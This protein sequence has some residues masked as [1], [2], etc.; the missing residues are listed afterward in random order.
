VF[1]IG[2]FASIFSPNPLL[3]LFAGSVL[4]GAIVLLWPKNDAPLLLLP[5][6]LQ[7]IAVSMKPLLTAVLGIPINQLGEYGADLEP[8][9]YFALVSLAALAIGMRI[10]SSARRREGVDFLAQSASR[11]RGRDV[12]GFSLAVMLFGHLCAIFWWHAGSAQQIVLGL[13]GIRLVGLFALTYWCLS[14]KKQ[15]GL[16]AAVVIF[17]VGFGMTG[18]FA[19][20]TAAVMVVVIA[21]LAATPRVRPAA[22]ILG[23]SGLA[24]LL[25][26]FVFWSAIKPDYR[27]FI[28][29]GRQDHVAVVPM[30]DRLQY[31][32]S[33]VASFDRAKF[34]DGFQR[35]VH[36]VGYIDFLAHTMENVPARVPHE[37][38]ARVL[39][40][41]AHVLQPRI[42]FPDKPAQLNDTIITAHYTGLSFPDMVYTSISIGYVGELYI[43][44]GLMGGV[45]AAL[46]LGAGI[47]RIYRLVRWFRGADSI[48]NCGFAAMA[49]LP[50][51]SYE[52][53]LLKTIGGGLMTL[54]AV[55]LLQRLVLPRL[56]AFRSSG[57]PMAKRQAHP[58]YR[59]PL[60]GRRL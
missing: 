51:I 60:Q 1:V 48:L 21:A 29:D 25:S 17:E 12:M 28:S 49:M 40:G 36:R 9:A 56:L 32:W 19:N 22:L 50:F 47:G 58:R 33:A 30:S 31:L 20:F 52:T 34:E 44:F 24:F 37:N 54:A 13:S 7:W 2:V 57:R 14:Q 55:L 27:N 59:P 42:F 26:A 53:G 39:E 10:G 38:G 15:R 5:F 18:Y 3:V 11:W 23:T 46:V 41:I 45:L 4:S 8:A 6:A 16:L 43:D 35:F